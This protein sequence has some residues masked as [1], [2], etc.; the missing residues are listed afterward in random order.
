M[1]S[2]DLD[3]CLESAYSRFPE[4]ERRPVIGLTGNFADGEVRLADR[5]YKSVAAAGGCQSVMDRRRTVAAS[6]FNQP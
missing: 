1:K 2:F 3:S 5:Y 6:S 4:A